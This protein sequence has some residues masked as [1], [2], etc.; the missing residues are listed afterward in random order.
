MLNNKKDNRFLDAL[1]DIDD[2]LVDEVTENAVRPSRA[3]QAPK[4]SGL[5]QIVFAAASLAAVAAVCI[6]VITLMQ[7]LPSTPPGEE[8]SVSLETTTS[9]VIRHT[10]VDELLEQEEWRDI[11][12]YVNAADEEGYSRIAQLDGFHM[13]DLDTSTET[14]TGVVFDRKPYM[15][16][17][18]IAL[19]GFKAWKDDVYTSHDSVNVGE[20]RIAL[21]KSGMIEATLPVYDPLFSNSLYIVEKKDFDK[22]TE[23]LGNIVVFRSL[24]ISMNK[25]YILPEA[26]FFNIQL[27]NVSSDNEGGFDYE[28]NMLQCWRSDISDNSK[29]EERSEVLSPAVYETQAEISTPEGTF[30]AFVIGDELTGTEY[31]F[32]GNTYTVRQKDRLHDEFKPF[33]YDSIPVIYSDPHYEDFENLAENFAHDMIVTER[34]LGE[35]VLCLVGD[36]FMRSEGGVVYFYDARIIIKKGDEPLASVPADVYWSAPFHCYQFSYNNDMDRLLSDPFMFGEDLFIFHGNHKDVEQ[37]WCFDGEHLYEP[38][39]SVDNTLGEEPSWTAS[40]DWHYLKVREE[41][42]SFVYG[43]RE[44]WFEMGDSEEYEYRVEW[45]EEPD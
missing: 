22:Y 32:L 17:Y 10:F 5:T 18:E 20:F 37:I 45:A 11:D 28:Y 31:C 6:G 41:S 16:G 34:K 35:Y 14:T 39:R 1:N 29:R 44:F 2:D 38:K 15:F 9:P 23:L 36:N 26:L 33:D 8:T 13:A 43:Y 24:N 12:S 4:R 7:N 19:L 21:V 25:Y 27:K 30:D 40:L 42:L 3:E